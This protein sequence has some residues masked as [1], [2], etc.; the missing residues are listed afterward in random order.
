MT[1]IEQNEKIASLVIIPEILFTLM[2]LIVL[3]FITLLTT[4]NFKELFKRSDL[5]FISI[6]FFGQTLVKFISGIAKS[7]KKK[8]WQIIAFFI[9]LLF[10][11]GIVPSILIFVVVYLNI[12]TSSYIYILQL[13]WLLLSLII[14]FIWGKIGQMYLDESQK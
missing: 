7:P 11:I 10:L 8:K 6:L 4:N 13:I 3:F 14:Y 12:N 1:K 9:S 2:P 5:S